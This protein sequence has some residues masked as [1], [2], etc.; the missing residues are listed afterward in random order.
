MNRRS[1]LKGV[2]SVAALAAMPKLPSR[3]EK[4]FIPEKVPEHPFTAAMKKLY[5]KE[6]LQ[7]VNLRPRWTMLMYSTPILFIPKKSV[8]FINVQSKDLQWQKQLHF[9]M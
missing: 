2:F 9:Q 4:T 5:P 3:I 6:R 7:E 8:Q 1:F